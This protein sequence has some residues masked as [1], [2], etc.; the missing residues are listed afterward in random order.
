MLTSATDDDF[1]TAARPLTS[2]R[3]AGFSS[4]A[5]KRLAHTEG[6]L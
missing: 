2:M 3:G 4:E 5:T 1:P 6:M